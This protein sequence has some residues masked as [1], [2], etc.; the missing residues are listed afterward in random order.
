MVTRTVHMEVVE[1]MS[2]EH[3]LM[4]FRRFVSRSGTPH[5]QLSDNGSQ[6]KLAK[7]T[8]DLAFEKSLTSENVLNYCAVNGINW[9]FI[10]ELSP[11]MGGFYECMVGVVKSSIKKTIRRTALESDFCSLHL[12][13]RLVEKFT[14]RKF[15]V[16]LKKDT[17]DTA[18]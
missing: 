4:A 11:W 9:N 6:F 12:L 2:S 1:N 15:E 18:S 5:Y 14:Q 13:V 17:E 8:I 3:F 10:V 16:I 7:S